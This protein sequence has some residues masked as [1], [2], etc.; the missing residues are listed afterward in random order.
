MIVQLYINL[1]SKEGS[2]SPFG[3]EE[4]T[5]PD[6]DEYLV[7]T[8]THQDEEVRRIRNRMEKVHQTEGDVGRPKPEPPPSVRE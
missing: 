1:I 4:W 8:L 7:S 3:E 2:V 5:S 6:W